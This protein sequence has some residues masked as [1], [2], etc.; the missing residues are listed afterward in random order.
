MQGHPYEKYFEQLKPALLSKVEEFEVL[1]YDDV[2]TDQL[3]T[4]LLR[5]KWKNV[6]EEKKL[7]QLVNDILSIKPT[8]YMTF[9]T[10]EAY[11]SP[12]W[13]VDLDEEELREL[14]RSKP[15]GKI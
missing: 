7:F 10:V 13:F 8:E 6:K 4:Y 12:N 5:K 11:R 2:T 1:G 14:L 9:A 15:R 3:W